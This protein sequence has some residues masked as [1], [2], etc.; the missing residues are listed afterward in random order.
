MLF[1]REARSEA[2]GR[3]QEPETI[4]LSPPIR[5]YLISNLWKLCA[6]F[7]NLRAKPLTV[8]TSFSCLHTGYTSWG[9]DLYIT[10]NYASVWKSPAKLCQIFTRVIENRAAP[11]VRYAGLCFRLASFL[12]SNCRRFVTSS[13]LPLTTH[14][15][16]FIIF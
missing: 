15:H 1:F 13:Y 8:D 11:L 16:V 7:K 3:G 4:P 12:P 14:C 10:R 5:C 9:V 6:V 2:K